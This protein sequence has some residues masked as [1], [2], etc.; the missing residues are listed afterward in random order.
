ME[1]PEP[2]FPDEPPVDPDDWTDEQW[3]RW[4]EATDVGARAEEEGIRVTPVRRIAHSPGHQVLGQAMLG[5]SNALYG[6]TQ[7]V[8]AIVTEAAPDL[9]EDEPFAVYLDPENPERS[10]VVFRPPR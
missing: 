2:A 9:D 3:V 8:I 5:L 1:A 6:R 7:D 4:L 10:S